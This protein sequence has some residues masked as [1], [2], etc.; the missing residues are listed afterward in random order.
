MPYLFNVVMHSCRRRNE[1]RKMSLGRHCSA[2]RALNGSSKT[3]SSVRLSVCS[4]RQLDCTQ[5]WLSYWTAREA[6]SELEPSSR[7]AFKPE[8][9]NNKGSYSPI[10]TAGSFQAGVQFN[11]LALVGPPTRTAFV[12]KRYGW[13][14]R[15]CYTKTACSQ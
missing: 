10:T 2:F 3:W 6:R 9:T 14:W 5:L 7:S 15:G 11:V 8:N 12:I 4:S 1:N 13:R